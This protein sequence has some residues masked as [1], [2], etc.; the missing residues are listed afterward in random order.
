MHEDD[1]QERVVVQ[2]P[3]KNCG[4]STADSSGQ[5][6]MQMQSSAAVELRCK[7][8]QMSHVLQDLR[9]FL[10]FADATAGD[11]K[12][13]ALQPLP[14]TI[15]EQADAALAQGPQVRICVSVL[16]QRCPII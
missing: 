10:A 6:Q 13:P 7:M 4:S 12:N 15:R 2:V 3:S 11:L 14:D 16:H 9:P 1:P 8:P 5:V